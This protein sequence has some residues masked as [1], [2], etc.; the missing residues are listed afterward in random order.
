M[1]TELQTTV[2]SADSNSVPHMDEEGLAY[3]VDVAQR[4]RCYL[5]YGSGGSTL[6]AANVAK[7]P[8]IISIESDKKWVD[9]VKAKIA[10]PHRG[11]YI[12]HCDI[13]EV[14]EWG[15][16]KGREKMENF[17]RYSAQPWQ[18]AR[19][20]QLVPDTV[21]IDGRFRVACFLTTLINAR[22]G[23]TALFDDYLDRPHYFV[24]E[25]FCPLVA[26]RGRMGIFSATR[27]FSVPTICEQ[28]A[29]YSVVSQ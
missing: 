15:T 14:T 20:R 16:P 8:A 25:E 18:T 9:K 17:W 28:L 10:M 5:E 19:A 26:K 3:F 13:G 21:L 29:R 12:E 23:T 11:I 4:S 7:V 27:S 24:V 2:P 22:I 1:Q 6:F